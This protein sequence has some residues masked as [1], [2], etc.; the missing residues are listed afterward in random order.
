[1]GGHRLLCGDCMRGGDVEAL[2]DGAQPVLVL[3]DPP[4]CSGGFQETEKSKGSRWH[5]GHAQAGR[6]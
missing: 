4:Y 3:T 2:F 6:E 5:H 1:M